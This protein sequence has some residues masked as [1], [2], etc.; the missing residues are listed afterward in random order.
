[1]AAATMLSTARQAA[2]ATVLCSSLKYRDRQARE[3]HATHG[4]PSQC[5]TPFQQALADHNPTPAL[6]PGW[7]PNC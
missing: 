7:S 2:A 6:T 1:M 5:A 4:D 3:P